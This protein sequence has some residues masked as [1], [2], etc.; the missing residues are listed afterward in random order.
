MVSTRLSGFLLVFIMLHVRNSTAL[1][2]HQGKEKAIVAKEDVLAVAKSSLINAH[3]TM[4]DEVSN[5]K[6]GGRKMMLK[7]VLKKDEVL[8]TDD[9]KISGAANF[10]DSCKKGILRGNCKLMSNRISSHPL[11][12]RMVGFTTF[13]ADYHVPKSHPPKNNR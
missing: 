8:N 12:D 11:N 10:E 1:I 2:T 9:T 5:T 3:A 7:M 13:S 4:A 6:L